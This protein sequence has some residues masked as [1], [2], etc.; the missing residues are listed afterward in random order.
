MIIPGVD[1]GKV[2]VARTRLDGMADHIEMIGSHP[3][4]MKDDKIIEQV[5]YFLVNGHF[6]RTAAVVEPT[7]ISM[8]D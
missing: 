8:G 5:V 7:H 1:D 3:F 2:S 4:L 6:N